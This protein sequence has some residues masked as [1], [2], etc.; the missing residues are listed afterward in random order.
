M[1][2]KIMIWAMAC[3]L[4][5]VSCA[6]WTWR[7]QR[8]AYCEKME[9][10][11]PAKILNALKA[12]HLIEGMNRKEANY[13][14]WSSYSGRTSY[15]SYRVGGEDYQVVTMWS[16]SGNRFIQLTFKNGF[17]ESWSKHFD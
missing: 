3:L 7:G 5:F 2:N 6:S 1:R 11:R 14:V 17:L 4:I 8:M 12:Y 16:D 15:D 13:V 9:G 10:K